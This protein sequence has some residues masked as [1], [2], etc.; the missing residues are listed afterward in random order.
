MRGLSRCEPASWGKTQPADAPSNWPWWALILTPRIFGFGGTPARRPAAG[1]IQ[2][3]RA[4]A[5][6]AAEEQVLAYEF[7]GYAL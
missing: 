3:I 2:L 7:Q 5:R 4:I 6:C 1:E